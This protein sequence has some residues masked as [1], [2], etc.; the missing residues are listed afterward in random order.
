[1]AEALRST[2]RHPGARLD[3]RDASATRRKARDAAVVPLGDLPPAGTRH[4]VPRYKAA[5]VAAVDAGVLTLDDARRRYLLSEEELD[6]WRDTIDRFGVVGLRMSVSERRHTQRTSVTERGFAALNAGERVE[7][8]IANVSD[9][10][11][12]LQVDAKVALPH[13]FELTCAATGRAWWVELVWQ[14]GEAA[15]VRFTN[16]LAPPFAIAEGLGAWLIGTRDSVTIGRL[17]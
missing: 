16:P 5:V 6:S 7:C 3:A 4:W 9:R 14:R 1:M 17:D 15:G 2:L 13:L 8:R 12:R 11:A 10:G